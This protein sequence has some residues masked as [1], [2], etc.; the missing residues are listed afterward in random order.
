MGACH[1]PTSLG[2]LQDG[3]TS[4]VQMPDRESGVQG[5]L[6]G[7]QDMGRAQVKEK[8]GISTEKLQSK[9]SPETPGFYGVPALTRKGRR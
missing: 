7:R 2:G 6:E 1:L 8:G 9:L 3:M 4:G 5:A